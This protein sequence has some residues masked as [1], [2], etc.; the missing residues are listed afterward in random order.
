MNRPVLVVTRL[1]RQ[2]MGGAIVIGILLLPPF[3]NSAFAHHPQ[4]HGGHQS[5]L[6]GGHPT[7]HRGRAHARHGS[8]RH[9]SVPYVL[10]GNAYAPQAVVVR[11]AYGAP[12][13]VTRFP[14]PLVVY[15]APFYSPH[16]A[17]RVARANRHHRHHGGR[18]YQG[19]GYTGYYPAPAG[20]QA[21]VGLW[22]DGVWVSV[23]GRLR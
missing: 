20:V 23:G 16:L 9:G 10:P 19:C 7:G 2:L 12:L 18:H 5:G 21:S 4:H 15:N 17:Q 11:P 14:P 13:P 1:A 6:Y 22:I 3:S 8:F